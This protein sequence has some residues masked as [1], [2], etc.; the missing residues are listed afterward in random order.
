MKNDIIFEF[1]ETGKLRIDKVLFESCYPILFTCLDE[2][3]NIYLCVCC[4][5]ENILKKWLLAKVEPSVIISLLRDQITL[6]NA[7]L[8]S[9]AKFSVIQDSSCT[10][11][12]IVDDHMDWHASNSIYLPSEGEYIEA[13]DGEFTEELLYFSKYIETNN[14]H[15]LYFDE[16]MQTE[17]VSSVSELIMAQLVAETSLVSSEEIYLEAA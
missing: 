12:L 4:T 8:S 7:F 1:K 6:R 16:Y 15:K 10:K 3:N 9:N 2:A 11:Y 14:K 13:D 17:D 5:A